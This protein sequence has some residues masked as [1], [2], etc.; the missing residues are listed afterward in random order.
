MRGTC[1]GRPRRFA[2]PHCASDRQP[3]RSCP[4]CAV[5]MLSILSCRRFR[6]SS[7]TRRPACRCGGV[8]CFLSCTR[9]CEPGAADFHAHGRLLRGNLWSSRRGD[10]ISPLHLPTYE[11]IS[12]QA[13][14]EE[15]F[16]YGRLQECL[17]VL[18]VFFADYI[19]F[20]TASISYTLKRKFIMSPSLTT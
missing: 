5:R 10:R 18:S 15:M 20:K 1:V 9:L 13:A 14:R 4:R 6:G 11:N 12:P 8:R 2:E 3:A 16:G 19:N 7:R 17:Q